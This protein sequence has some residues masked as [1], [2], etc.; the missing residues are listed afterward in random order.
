MEK[1]VEKNADIYSTPVAAFV[2]FTTQE[3]YERCLNEFETAQT[4]FGN[5]IYHRHMERQKVFK[6][7]PYSTK[8]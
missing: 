1:L 4:M 3:G 8:E 5:P 2:T 6:F 7:D